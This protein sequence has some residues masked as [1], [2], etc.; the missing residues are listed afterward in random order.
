MDKPYQPMTVD[1]N[2]LVLDSNNPRFAELYS[3][4][5]ENDLIEYIMKNEAGDIIAKKIVEENDFYSDEPLWV[6]QTGDCYKVYDGNRRCAAVKALK[7]PELFD[8]SIG[9]YEILELPVLLYTDEQLLKKRIISQHTNNLFREWERIAKALDVYKMFQ[10]GKSVEDMREFDSNPSDLIKLASFYYEAAKIAGDDLKRLMRRGRGKTGG[11]TI[12]FERLYASSDFSKKC[13]YYFKRSPHYTIVISNQAV[14][15]SYILSLVKYLKQHPDVTHKN[16]DE[17]R[18]GFLEKLKNYG[19][20]ENISFEPEFSDF[21]QEKTQKEANNHN[22][23]ENTNE[24]LHNKNNQYSQNNAS[25]SS[26]KCTIKTK[27]SLGKKGLAK[28]IK[29][30][31]DESFSLDSKLFPNAK[32]AIGRVLFECIL[33]Y[34][35]ENIKFN[36]KTLKDYIYF[37]NAFYKRTGEKLPYTDF[38]ALKNLFKDL[39]VDVATQNAFNTFDIDYMHQIIHNHKVVAAPQDAEAVYTNLIPLIEFMLQDE[40]ELTKMLD[41]TKLI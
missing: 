15:S 5:D 27:P 16:V 23:E 36:K 9:K 41:A 19:F 37:K 18:D 11:K 8:L 26:K 25:N 32:T 40:N 39:I 20:D 6:M 22:K 12:I 17:D 28:S 2:K 13:G 14:F 38:K 1:V 7:N 29:T 21:S 34:I 35:V 3:S 30:L 31:I 33:K 4:D 10:N 24:G